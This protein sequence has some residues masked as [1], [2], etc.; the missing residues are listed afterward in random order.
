M[1]IENT[2]SG[3]QELSVEQ[4]ASA[5]VKSTAQEPQG[6]TAE[7][8]EEQG[9]EADD[10][11]QASDQDEGEDD[12]DPEEEG[13]AEEEAGDEP[14]DQGRFVASNGKV[15]LP[16]GSV[17]TVADLVQGNLRH[18]DYTQ[19]TMGLAEERRT[20]EAQSSA[21]KASQ[22]QVDQQ[23]D[24][25]VQ[26]LQSLSPQ[27]PDPSLIADGSPNYDPFKY[28]AQKDQHERFMGHLNM[29]LQ[30][31]EASKQA[32]EGETK[33]QRDERA[34]VEWERL[35]E[36]L[37]EV[38][39][40]AKADV[41]FSTVQKAGEAAGFSRQELVEAL[42]YDHRLI[43]V[44]LKAARWDKLQASKPKAVQNVQNR[45]PVQKAGK[46][47]TPDAQRIRRS[48]DAVNRL[49]QSGT[50]EDAARAYLASMKG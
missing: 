16:D 48:E 29:L 11:L 21:F 24:Y 8:D 49:K 39:D 2:D 10:E 7:Q 40:K 13:Q 14:D 17:L 37:P 33:K 36:A 32:A 22:Q 26:L 31:S 27:P 9:E 15:R 18:R 20:F 5:F 23:R 3:E 50:V 43:P 30:Q 28:M 35:Q 1:E 6:Q 12:G 38:R 41:V 46:R 25:M 19:K 34:R 44:L 47:M 45:P 4:A 42:P